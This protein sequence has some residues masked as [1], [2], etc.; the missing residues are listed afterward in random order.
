VLRAG[1]VPAL[2]RFGV[3]RNASVDNLES[4]GMTQDDRADPSRTATA[5]FAET[6][7]RRLEAMRR[8]G[9]IVE[10]EA[11]GTWIIA[12]DHLE[13]A[14]NF[15]RAQARTNPV[16]VETL[17]ALPLDRPVRTEGA[18]W[19]DRELVAAAPIPLRDAGFGREVRD[20]LARRHQWL[21]EQELQI[22]T[23]D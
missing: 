5:N 8:L 14:A 12:P 2:P 13:R 6:H 21:I 7:V 17:S 3:G 9:G 20:G 22:R 11:D 15:E 16:L 4:H 10:R 18:T 1:N 23:L 19:L